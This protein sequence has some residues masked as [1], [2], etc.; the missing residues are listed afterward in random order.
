MSMHI[1]FLF[2]MAAQVSL[3]QSTLTME[4]VNYYRGIHGANAVQADD[5]LIYDAYLA[6]KGN[7]D[8]LSAGA[9]SHEVST[10]SRR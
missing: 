1:I 9:L 4:W 7:C 5:T 10:I 6:A 2:L 8:Y 3:I